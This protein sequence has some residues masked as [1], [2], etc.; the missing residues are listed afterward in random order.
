M[1]VVLALALVE[2]SVFLGLEESTGAV[3]LVAAIGAVT[4]FLLARLISP[5]AAVAAAAVGLVLPSPLLLASL[6][7]TG[8]LRSAAWYGLLAAPVAAAALAGSRL[9][10][11]LP[12]K[13][14]LAAGLGAAAAAGVSVALAAPGSEWLEERPPA[15]YALIDDVLGA[16]GP[17]ALGG[18]QEAVVAAFGRRSP[19]SAREPLSP[20]GADEE[21]EGPTFV[22]ASPQGV[23]RYEDVVFWFEAGAV[24]GF[25]LTSPGAETSRGIEV[26]DGLDDVRAA[27]PKLDCGEAPAGESSTFTYCAGRLAPERWVWFG[28]DPVSTIAFS[29]GPFG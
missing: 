27:Y 17:V 16:Y 18:S 1:A 10:E 5:N 25:M 15:R 23:Y 8:W 6:T 11:L 20:T 26:G 13:A 22:A 9:A 19:T 7:G 14:V 2:S 28:G 12:L 4:G 29:R 21:Y 3:L 24:K